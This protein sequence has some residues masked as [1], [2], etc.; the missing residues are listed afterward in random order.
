MERV[1]EGKKIAY[2]HNVEI[3]VDT[4]AQKEIASLYRAGAKI[5]VCAWDKSVNGKNK[6]KEIYL[7]GIKLCVDNI[8]VKV[9]KTKGLKDNIIPLL[10]YQIRLLIWLIKY[11]KQFEYIHA[12]DLD[13]SFL[14]SIFCRITKKIFIYDIFDDYADCHAPRG[15]KL[16]GFIRKIDAGIIKRSDAVIICSEKRKEQLAITPKKLVIIHNSPDIVVTNESKSY[17]IDPAKL[18]VV[19]VG[20]LN[21]KRMTMELAYLIS[22]SEEMELYCGGAGLY[23]DELRELSEKYPNI[24]FYGI[25]KYE[26]VISL[27]SQCDVIPALYDPSF[28]NHTYAAPNKFYEALSLGKPSIMIQNTGMD[29]DVKLLNSGVVIDYD[30][31]SLKKALYKILE[32]KDYW[33]K[34]ENELKENFERLYSWKM[35]EKR[36]IGIYTE[37][38]TEL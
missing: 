11:R 22:E 13:V 28:P 19:Y 24:H 5:L 8:C 26:D 35:M 34:K 12:V 1:L 36:L 32:N 38:T 15:S 25:M 2:V 31:E 20:N 37:L 29:K 17:G 7:R 9:K 14:T 4:R 18:N 6:H 23:E 10:L 33:R 21:P 16:H 3:E 30:K 27:E